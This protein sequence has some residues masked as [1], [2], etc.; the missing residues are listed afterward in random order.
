MRISYSILCLQACLERRYGT[1]TPKNGSFE[2]RKKQS[3][4]DME[5]VRYGTG[6]V[7]DFLTHKSAKR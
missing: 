5:K 7:P 6:T 2:L 4:K 1:V 3:L